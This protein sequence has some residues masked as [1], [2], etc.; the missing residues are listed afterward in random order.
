MGVA[1]RC[2]D[3]GRIFRVHGFET[4]ARCRGCNTTFNPQTNPV[5]ALERAENRGESQ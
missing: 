3:C 4:H 5:L 2:P 1:I